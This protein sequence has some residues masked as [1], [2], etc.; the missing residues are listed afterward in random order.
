MRTRSPTRAGLPPEW[1]RHPKG[2]RAWLALIACSLNPPPP[3]MG[4]VKEWVSQAQ[5]WAGLANWS[6]SGGGWGVLVEGDL[7]TRL[8]TV[9]GCGSW[10]LPFADFCLL[11]FYVLS[12]AHVN[13]DPS[14][15]TNVLGCKGIRPFWAGGGAHT[16]SPLLSGRVDGPRCGWE[17]WLGLPGSPETP[18]RSRV[19]RSN[20]SIACACASCA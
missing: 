14:K 4:R 18:P 11:P 17:G 9:V 15:K 1:A 2:R 19:S 7:G 16:P 5:F 10:T 20:G 12:S 6:P 3:H 8:N 13:E